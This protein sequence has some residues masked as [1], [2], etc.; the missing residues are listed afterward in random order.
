MIPDIET[1]PLQEIKL[2]Q[3]ARLRETLRYV[4]AHSP[5][6]NALFEKY[7]LNVENIQTLEDLLLLPTV[8]KEDLQLYNADFLC[9]PKN[10]II[11]YSATSGTMGRPV[12]FGLTDNDLERLAY[13]EAI[14]F[15]CAGVQKGDLVQLMTTIDRRFMAGMAYFLGLR[16]VGAGIIRVGPGIAELHWSSIMAHRPKYIIAVPSFIPKLLDYAEANRIDY[17]NCGVVGAI[18]IGEPVRNADLTPNLLAKKITNRWNIALFSTYASTEMATA[19][20]EC[21]YRQGGHHHPELIIAEVLGD[22]GL[23]VADGEIGELTV[24]TLGVEAMPL[25]RFKTGDMVNVYREPCPCGRTT[26]RLGPVVGRKQQMIKYKGTILFPP[27]LCDILGSHPAIDSYVVELRSNEWGSDDLL[28]KIATRHPE[29]DIT[30]DLESQ[31]RA[32]IRVLPRIEFAD[33]ES[34][35]KVVFSGV[36]RKPVRVVDL[37]R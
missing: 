36:N 24:T 28:V 16:K 9:V 35:D 33:R 21:E 2:L 18:C 34:L 1:Q 10:H 19:F 3:E 31:F 5:F 4:A 32:S 23:P 15:A 29:A 12:D 8:S 37:R 6:Y 26:L 20:T 27:A 11:D 13:N 14:S 17:H 7:G 30:L 25:V 22:D